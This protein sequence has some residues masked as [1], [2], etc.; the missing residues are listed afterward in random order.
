MSVCLWRRHA[1]MSA[2][3]PVSLVVMSASLVAMSASLVAMSASLVAMAM[4]NTSTRSSIA[5]VVSLVAIPA[6]FRRKRADEFANT[7]KLPELVRL[8][9]S[10]YR[11]SRRLPH[12]HGNVSSKW[13]ALALQLLQFVCIWEIYIGGSGAAALQL[14]MYGLKK[15]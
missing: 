1:C 9:G 10:V 4:S 11:Q 13:R 12:A 14:L 8:L 5:T 7:N 3:V 2:C 15:L 6:R